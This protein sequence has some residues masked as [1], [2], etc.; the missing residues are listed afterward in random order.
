M[1]SYSDRKWIQKTYEF[2]TQTDDHLSFV[3]LI[4]QSFIIRFWMEPIFDNERE[5]ELDFSP[6][7]SQPPL[8]RQAFS[9]QLGISPLISNNERLGKHLVG[10][11]SDLDNDLEVVLHQNKTLFSNTNSEFQSTSYAVNVNESV[12]KI[13]HQLLFKYIQ[14]LQTKY[15][16]CNLLEKT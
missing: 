11:I 1:K 6:T 4:E 14:K 7:K 8:K 5:E 9:T 10:I 3:N 2:L 12:K 15:A 16:K 13:L